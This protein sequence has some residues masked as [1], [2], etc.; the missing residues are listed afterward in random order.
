MGAVKGKLNLH[1]ELKSQKE[2][3]ISSSVL[4]VSD[5]G[6]M[7]I[8]QKPGPFITELS[9]HMHPRSWEVNVS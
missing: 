4:I 7:G 8:L 3:P 6:A 9:I 2:G 1:Q 5:F